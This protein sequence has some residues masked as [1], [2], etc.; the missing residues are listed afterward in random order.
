MSREN[1]I[2]G[3][4]LRRQRKRY[5]WTQ[6]NLA[7]RLGVTRAAVSR[8]ELGHA[9]PSFTMLLKIRSNLGRPSFYKLWDY[10]G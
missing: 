2:F 5:G 8:V 6:D 10:H 3:R 9:G 1:V 4:L 7:Q